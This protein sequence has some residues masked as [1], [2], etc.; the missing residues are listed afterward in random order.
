[1]PVKRDEIVKQLRAKGFRQKEGD[2]TFF[3]LFVEGKKT[4]VFTKVSGGSK[5]REYGDA[6]L[7]L[8]RRQMGL[9]TAELHEFIDCKLGYDGYVKILKARNRIR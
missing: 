3:T 8:V 9:T 6:L 7:D 1:M 2:H 4:S 5:Y